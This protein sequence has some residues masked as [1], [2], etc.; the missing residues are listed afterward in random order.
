MILILTLS[1]IASAAVTGSII[2]NSI[3]PVLAPG[4]TQSYTVDYS[5]NITSGSSK[6]DV[7]FL[8]DSTLS[9]GGYISG[10]RD[11]LDDIISSV[12]TALP[13][14]DIEYGVADYR[15]YRDF[16]NY[17]NYGVNLRQPFTSDTA[18]VNSAIHSMHAA[19]GYDLPESQLKAMVN[20]ANNWMTPSGDLGFGGR[21]DAQKI[22][23]WAGDIQGH[24]LGEEAENRDGPPGYYPSLAGTL[25]A[26]N[27]K[28]ILTFGL[29]L[30]DG[31]AGIDAD[32]GGDNQATYLT[33]GTGGTLL[34]NLAFSPAT[35]EAAIVDAVMTGIDVLSNITLVLDGERNF[36]IDPITQTAIGS[37]EPEDGDVTGSFTFDI[38]GALEPGSA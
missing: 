9:M 16:G 24:Y 38:T 2:P 31:E 4:Q 27:A 11:A 13:D 25:E 33:A 6:A 12:D 1:A 28:G 7:L 14:A 3:S 26:L 19:G 34:N 29:N 23:I 35:I 15:D 8:T 10:I 20:L 37:W 30:A 36:L 17:S 32:Y 18:A 21:A 5:G 22:V